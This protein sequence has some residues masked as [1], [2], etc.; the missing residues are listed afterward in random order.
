MEIKQN[1]PG[2]GQ[3]EDSDKQTLNYEKYWVLPEQGGEWVEQ[4]L[5]INKCTWDEHRMTCG[6]VALYFTPET[7]ITL[8]LHSLQFKLKIMY[9]NDRYLPGFL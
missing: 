8:Y 4:L 6:R 1:K 9:V 7:N 5:G 2:G 3:G